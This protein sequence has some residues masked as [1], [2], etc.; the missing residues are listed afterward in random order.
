MNIESSFNIIKIALFSISGVP[1]RSLVTQLLYS[2][3]SQESQTESTGTYHKLIHVKNRETLIRL[4]DPPVITDRT[5]FGDLI[6]LIM[7]S[8]AF[9]LCY[10]VTSRASFE[11]VDVIFDQIS[12]IRGAENMNV[13]FLVGINVSQS[14][15][16]IPYEYGAKLAKKKGTEFLEVD[17]THSDIVKAMFHRVVELALDTS[18]SDVNPLSLIEQEDGEYAYRAPDR[19]LTTIPEEVIEKNPR[20]II[21]TNN[22]LSTLPTY[23]IK[24]KLVKLDISWNLFETFPSVLGLS[25]IHI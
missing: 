21:V 19:F 24:L 9:I 11:A 18:F 10:S 6:S 1:K 17:E 7:E 4:A 14:N 12:F 3:V 23:L 16:E 8:N 15:R 2:S 5:D 13:V 22:N 25:L 20:R